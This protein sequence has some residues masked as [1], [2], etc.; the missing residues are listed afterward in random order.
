M[1]PRE[2]LENKTVLLGRAA[3]TVGCALAVVMRDCQHKTAFGH[4]CGVCQET[5]VTL[6]LQWRILSLQGLKRAVGMILDGVEQH[7]GRV[8]VGEIFSRVLRD[9]NV[10]NN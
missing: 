5:I 3:Q 8:D 10:H 2:K 7:P 6:L 1:I 4:P 9:E